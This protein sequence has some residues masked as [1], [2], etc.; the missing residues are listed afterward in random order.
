MSRRWLLWLIGANLLAAAALVF[1]FPHLM[2]SPGALVSGHASLATDCFACHAP[3]RGAV[4]ERCVACHALPDIGLRTTRGLAI[5]QKPIK[6]S[7]HQDLI[8]Q[9]CMACHS[10]HLGPKLTQ[11]SRKP[12]SHG[13]LRAAVR[14]RCESCHRV[15]VDNL[16]R[17]VRGGCLQCHSQEA[18]KPATFEHDK[19]FLLDR[20]H[21]TTC[22]TCHKGSDYSRY[23]C[24]GC[25]EHQ[26][27][28][29]RAEHLEEGI[30]DVENCVECHRS[31][32]DEPEGRGRN[33][34]R[35]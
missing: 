8:E 3:G 9:D 19:L 24:Y 33:G 23:T 10:D 22:E 4:S 20:D 30:R 12:F 17:Q 11:R 1:V 18:W 6:A 35:D 7:F 31:A 32:D 14:E 29:I 25:H 28:K 26:P 27:A 16:H 13:L 2:V 34:E 5:S 21:D 15:P